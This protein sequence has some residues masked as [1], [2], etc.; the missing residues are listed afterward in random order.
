MINMTRMHIMNGAKYRII[1]TRDNDL[2]LKIYYRYI[3]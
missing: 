2:R 1:T 3:K